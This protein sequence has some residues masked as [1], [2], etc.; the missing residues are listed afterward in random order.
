MAKDYYEVLGIPRNADANEIKKAYRKL[1]MQYHP[2][3]NPGDKQAEEKFKEVSEAY[4][5]LKDPDKRRQYDQFGQAGLRGGF[6]TFS[7]FGFDLSDALRTFMSEGFGFEDFFGGGARSR[8]SRARTRGSDLQLRLELTYEEIATGVTKKIKL[9]RYE[10]CD[11]CGGNGLKKGSTPVT[12]SLCHGTGEIRQASRTIFGQFINVTTCSQC[13]GEGK[14]IKDACH[15]CAGEGRLKTDATLTVNIPAGVATGNYL[16]LRGEGHAGPRGGPAGDAIV[17][18]EEKEHPYFERHGDD[19]LYDLYLS[20]SQVALGDEVEVPTLNGRASLTIVPGTQ[21][22][23]ILRMRG[24]GIPHLNHSGKGDQLVR[25]LVWTPTK[26]TEKEKK[27]FRE[28]AQSEAVRPP[29]ADKSFFKKVKD[30]LFE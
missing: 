19:I 15:A 2:D 16:T 5:V 7:S 30:A 21:S 6:D 4:E 28:L 25:V 3:K 26:L 11:V 27:L 17:V 22:G 23:K 18:I 29:Q 9:K 12:C 20:F 10:K 8:G 13:H 1:A 24:K 14:T